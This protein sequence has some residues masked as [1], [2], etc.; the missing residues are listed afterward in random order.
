MIARFIL[1]LVAGVYLIV[2]P[3]LAQDISEADKSAFQSIITQQ[4]EAFKVGDHA[5]AYSL[6]SPG[7]QSKFRNPVVFGQMARKGY[8]PVTAPQNYVFGRVSDKLGSPT[9]HVNLTGPAGQ[10]WIAL[11]GFEK[12]SDDSWRINGVVLIKVPGSEV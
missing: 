1:T 8:A 5:T 9:Q 12:Q 3:A 6:A 4:I 7:V 2:A 10:N 11:Y